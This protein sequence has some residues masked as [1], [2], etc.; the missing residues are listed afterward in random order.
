MTAVIYGTPTELPEPEWPEY[1]VDGRFSI[2]RMN[3]LNDKFLADLRAW[4][5]SA[6]YTGELTGE[7]V[8]WVRGDGYAS[9]MVMSLRPLRLMHI[10]LGD[11][12][13]M[14]AIFERGLTAADIR[15]NIARIQVPADHDI[16]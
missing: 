3:E 13:R 14:D 9:Y 1:K 8:R 5:T 15:T 6:G 10:P 2:D 16:S 12:W 4:L 11:A 7:V